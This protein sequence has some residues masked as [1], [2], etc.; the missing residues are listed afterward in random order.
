MR[1][2]AAPK[3]VE[4]S[5]E[6]L[7][8]HLQIWL[9]GLRAL[10]PSFPMAKS[11]WLGKPPRIPPS[12]TESFSQPYRSPQKFAGLRPAILFAGEFCFF[13]LFGH[14]DAFRLFLLQSYFERHLPI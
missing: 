1:W 3:G 12:F 10:D 2:P 6:L 7:Q 14:H 5:A 9:G 4:T 8:A 13:R 11:I